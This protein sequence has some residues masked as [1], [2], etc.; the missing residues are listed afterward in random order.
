VCCRAVQVWRC[1]QVWSI[2]PGEG[3]LHMWWNFVSVWGRLQVSQ[4]SMS[5]WRHWWVSSVSYTRFVVLEALLKLCYIFLFPLFSTVYACTNFSYSCYFL[6]PFFSAMHLIIMITFP[7]LSVLKSAP[8]VV[9]P[10]VHVGQRTV[11]AQREHAHVVKQVSGYL[12]H[13]HIHV[14]WSLWLIYFLP[15]HEA[16]CECGD[17]CTCTKGECTCENCQCVTCN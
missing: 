12:L 13:S 4:R 6:S 16:G 15:S 14:L 9:E 8:N 5:L 11:S 10:H 1:L 3:V 17:D 2:V 7:S